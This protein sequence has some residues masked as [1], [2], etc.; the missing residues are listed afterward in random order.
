MEDIFNKKN[1]FKEFEH[2]KSHL[3][4]GNNENVPC[5][6]VSIIMPVYKRPD[7][8]K[9]SL[10]T[11]INQDFTQPYEIVVVDNYDGEGVSPNLTVVKKINNPKI[12]YYHNELNL[13]LFGNWNRGI[14][15]ARADYVTYCHDDDLLLPTC[16]TRLMQLQKIAGDK[17]ILSRYHI[18]DEEGKLILNYNYPHYKFNIF[19]E[20]DHYE[21]SLYNQFIASMGF[22]VGCLFN[23]K[24]MLDLGGYN[25]SYDT[26]SDYAFQASYTFYYGC[27]INN[28]PTFKYRIAINESK[29]VYNLFP[30]IDKYYR[31]CM[32]PKLSLPNWCLR[33][34]ILA[35]YR[36]SKITYAIKWNDAPKSLLKQISFS[37]KLVMRL[38]SLPNTIKN[39][40]IWFL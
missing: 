26:S 4:Y 12:I 17:C 34:I 31:E 28:I 3:L 10:E 2:V 40:H 27:V 29:R 23:R 9:L 7:L 35:N 1:C 25:N 22:G 39:Y 13:G 36:K 16:L 14:E 32:I 20:K 33:R 38:A 5:P 37:D 24:C 18:I 11:A 19:R 15:L 6:M 30:D 21:Y 8:F